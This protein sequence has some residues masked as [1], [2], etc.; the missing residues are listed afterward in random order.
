MTI[1]PASHTYTVTDYNGELSLLRIIAATA[2]E[3]V[4]PKGMVNRGADR[5]LVVVEKADKS[6]PHYR[7]CV[8]LET[9]RAVQGEPA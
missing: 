4:G 3:L 2:E 7:L 6:D 1:A 8:A 5:G 9:L